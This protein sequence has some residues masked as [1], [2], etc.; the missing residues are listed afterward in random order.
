MVKIRI[1]YLGV[2]LKS[3]FF[4]L[5]GSLSALT[6]CML[7]N[8][9]LLLLKHTSFT[10]QVSKQL[11]STPMSNNVIKSLLLEILYTGII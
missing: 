10:I 7:I 4:T 9:T 8:T 2:Y 3:G 6:W 11:I 1:L 5:K